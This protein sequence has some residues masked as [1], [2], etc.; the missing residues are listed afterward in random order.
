[1]LLYKWD[2]FSVLRNTL[3]IE[4]CW[5]SLPVNRCNWLL[6][7]VWKMHEWKLFSN[8][9]ELQWIGR[10]R[11][12]IPHGVVVQLCQNANE[13][14]EKTFV[15]VFSKYL[16]SAVRSR[17]LVSWP[18]LYLQSL[19]CCWFLHCFLLRLSSQTH[20]NCSSGS[21]PLWE[22]TLWHWPCSQQPFTACASRYCRQASGSW[23]HQQE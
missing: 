9:T 16:L 22:Q 23:S 4:K 14:Q 13:V 17:T 20:G 18:F 5:I 2:V 21:C 12:V 8:N 6:W 7:V 3:S 15:E 11:R 10:K 1:M 19:L